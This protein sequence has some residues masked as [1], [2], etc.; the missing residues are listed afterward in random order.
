MC[1]GPALAAP[2]A[3]VAP[4]SQA[5]A[6]GPKPARVLPLRTL[7]ALDHLRHVPIDARIEPA[8]I[9][10]DLLE[11]R[12]RLAVV[13]EGFGLRE[14]PEVPRLDAARVLG[15]GGGSAEDD[16]QGKQISDGG[17]SFFTFVH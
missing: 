17:H 12:R 6:Q 15:E 11:V 16:Q 13:A 7:G 9:D 14:V 3:L 8:L 10:E 5:G 4:E 1:V 2:L